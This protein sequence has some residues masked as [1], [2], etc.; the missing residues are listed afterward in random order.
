MANTG[1]LNVRVFV[2][3]AQIPLEGATVVITR[4][5]PGGKYDLLSVQAT[6]SSGRIRPVEVAVPN[7]SSTEPVEAGGEVPYA[8]CN[9]WAE[10]PGFMMLQVEGV[11]VFAGVETE[12][13]ME[14]IP[15]AQGQQ[16]LLRRTVRKIT[17]QNL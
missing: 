5:V 13:D 6:D 4:D 1:T 12:Q 3:Q 9:V 8:L 11:Q 16:S 15:L 2:T 17:G 7:G 14:M 10:H